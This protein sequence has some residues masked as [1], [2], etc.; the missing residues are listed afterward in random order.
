MIV[1]FAGYA[2]SG[3]DSAA[4]ALMSVGFSRIAFADK[5]REFVYELN[6]KVA[7]WDLRKI[8]DIYGWNGYKETSWGDSIRE[9]LQYVGTDLARNILGP[10]VWVNATLQSISEEEDL[11]ITDVRFPNEADAIRTRGGKVFL[12]QRRGVGPANGHSSETALE[13]YEFDDIIFN[14]GTLS[15]FHEKVKEMVNENRD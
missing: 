1:G 13:N 6:P 15:E 11:V 5:L 8:I 14:N 7:G 4:D 3:K 12:I 10:D 9:Q 2:R